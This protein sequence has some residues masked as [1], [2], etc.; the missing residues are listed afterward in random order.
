MN[1]DG[2]PLTDLRGYE[3]VYGTGPSTLDRTVDVPSP[4]ILS[5]VI[6][7]LDPG[8]WYFAVRAYNARGIESPLSNVAAKTIH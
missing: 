4:G 1:T 2:S 6:D 8:T 7:E 5:V 3:V